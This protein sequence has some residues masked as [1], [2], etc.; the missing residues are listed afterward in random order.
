PPGSGTSTP[1]PAPG[2]RERS[3]KLR[4]LSSSA[5]R[6]FSSTISRRTVGF[7]GFRASALRVQPSRVP[8]ASVRA[9]AMVLRSVMTPPPA[10]LAQVAAGVYLERSGGAACGAGGCGDLLEQR[11]RLLPAEAGVRDRLPVA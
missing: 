6:A 7:R 9:S 11:G 8:N 10:P 2:V 5:M 4:R 1:S 3:W